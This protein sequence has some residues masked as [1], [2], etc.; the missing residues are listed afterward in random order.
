MKWFKNLQQ[1]L[2]SSADPIDTPSLD[3]RWRDLSLGK[4]RCGCCDKN[5]TDLLSMGY[6][7]PEDWPSDKIRASSHDIDLADE[8]FLTQDLC[9]FSNRHFVRAVLLLPLLG[10]EVPFLIGIWVEISETYFR[11][12]A[13]EMPSG[14]QGQLEIMFCRLANIIPPFRI[15]LPCIMK[16][17][18]NFQRPVVHIAIEEDPLYAAQID[19]LDFDQLLDML[20]PHGHFLIGGDALDHL[21]T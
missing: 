4:F 1:N 21:S 18:D 20:R 8:T 14:K 6:S 15:G 12:F 3:P 7:A 13:A 9:K 16:P 17:R 5:F 10:S 19:G 2:T 11:S